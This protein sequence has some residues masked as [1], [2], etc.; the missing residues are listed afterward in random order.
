MSD[1]IDA[2]DSDIVIISYMLT[3]L[4]SSDAE[5]QF[6]QAVKVTEIVDVAGPIAEAAIGFFFGEPVEGMQ[7]G[8]E[9]AKGFDTAVDTLSDVFDFLGVHFGPPNCNGEVFHDTLLLFSK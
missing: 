6:A 3:N 8:E 4:G 5:E 9:V 2:K 7:I 1:R